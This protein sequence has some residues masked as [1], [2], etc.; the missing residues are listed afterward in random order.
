MAT[1]A[2]LKLPLANRKL[3]TKFE[4]T[5]PNKFKPRIII[6]DVPSSYKE[7][8][9]KNHVSR[10]NNLEMQQEEFEQYFYQRFK[11]GQRDRPVTN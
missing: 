3:Q 7:Q 6:C 4:V 9:L 2:N 1:L 8:D 10:Q 11:T 5:E